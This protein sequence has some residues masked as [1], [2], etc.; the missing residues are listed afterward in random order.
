[1]GLEVAPRGDH[2]VRTIAYD[3]KRIP[4]GS[5]SFG[6]VACVDTPHHATSPVDVLREA[7]R[8]SQGLVLVKDRFCENLLD[9]VRLTT[10]YGG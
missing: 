1:M 8:V 6:T 3:G 2:L 5:R 9:L 10:D 7:S 4:F